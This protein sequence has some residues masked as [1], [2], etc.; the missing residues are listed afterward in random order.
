MLIDKIELNSFKGIEILSLD[1]NE[2]INLIYGR[3]ELGKSTIIEAINYSLFED[4][5]GNKIE[6]KELVPWNRDVK[7]KV[8]LYF[9]IKNDKYLV[10]KS[11]PKGE[12]KLFII[13]NSIINI[14][15]GKKTNE[16]ILSLLGI[17]EKIKNLYNLLWINQGDTLSIFSKDFEKSFNSDTQTYI[18][19]IIK[20]SLLSKK[21]ED[22]YQNI[23]KKLEEV[24]TPVSIKNNNLIP[25]CFFSFYKIFL[26]KGS[27]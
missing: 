21:N 27:I 17:D 1:F 7:A 8:K 24:F 9:T 10:E 5:T 2:G 11:F 18:K 13:T 3:N 23:L 12:Q 15:D 14:A 4:A 26:H 19:D 16:K 6:Y 22:F 20:E 25:V